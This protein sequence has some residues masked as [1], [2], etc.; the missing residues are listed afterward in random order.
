MPENI[1]SGGGSP[2]PTGRSPLVLDIERNIQSVVQ[3]QV[4]NKKTEIKEKRLRV[5]ENEQSMLDALDASAI[6]GVGDKVALEFGNELEKLSTDWAKKFYEKG[7]ELNTQDKLELNK[8]KRNIESKLKSQAADLKMMA[9]VQKELQIQA[10]RPDKKGIYDF[11]KTSKWLDEYAKSGKAGSGGFINGIV[12]AQP[13]FGE[14]FKSKYDPM[15]K[16]AV[17]STTGTINVL[18]PTTGLYEEKTTTKPAMAEVKSFLLQTPEGQQLNDSDPVKFNTLVDQMLNESG[19][20]K[21]EQGFNSGLQRQSGYGSGADDKLTTDFLNDFAEGAAR[22]NPDILKQFA[23]M[24]DKEVGTI[25]SAGYDDGKLYLY[26]A[27]SEKYK[28]IAIPLP[29]PNDTTAR[30]QFK[31]NLLNRF[32]QV[33][34]T[35]VGRE[36]LN[37]IKAQWGDNVVTEPDMPLTLKSVVNLLNVSPE[38]KEKKSK[39]TTPDNVVT[40]KDYRDKIIDSIKKNVNEATVSASKWK[41]LRAGGDNILEITDKDGNKKEYDLR[42]QSDRQ[43]LSDWIVEN[44]KYKEKFMKNLGYPTTGKPTTEFEGVPEGG[45]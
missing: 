42:E 23:G 39:A 2:F 32:S 31:R 19:F 20:T 8:A 34:N 36:Q 33:G 43:E 1:Y 15:V 18:N 10:T 12:F 5:T 14:E 24:V 35:E 25:S 38:E 13:E 41:F 3:Q 9:D 6:E 17:K 40:A 45:F 22:A 4:E 44:S 21:T 7:G 37:A 11:E 30:L 29:K 26:P 27:N 16:N 28:P